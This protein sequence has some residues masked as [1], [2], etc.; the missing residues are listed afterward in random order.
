MDD[1][2]AISLAVNEIKMMVEVAVRASQ[3]LLGCDRVDDYGRQ[4]FQLP[5]DDANLLDFAILNV[6]QR[7]KA[8]QKEIDG[9]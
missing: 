9:C 2:N 3:S 6:E 1:K 8:L 7:I 5:A 4:M